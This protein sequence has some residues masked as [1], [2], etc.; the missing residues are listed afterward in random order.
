[1]REPEV[2]MRISPAWGSCAEGLFKSPLC[3]VYGISRRWVTQEGL[4]VGV[5]LPKSFFHVG[6]ST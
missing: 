6:R 4:R 2:C 1:M 5:L 3:R